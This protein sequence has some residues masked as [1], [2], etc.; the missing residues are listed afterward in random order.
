MFNKQNTIETNKKKKSRLLIVCLFLF[1]VIVI[2]ILI[3]FFGIPAYKY[4][5][6]MNELTVGN[7]DAAKE[8]FISLEDYRDS[9][10]LIDESDYLKAKDELEGGNYDIAKNI[11]NDLGEYKD[12]ESYIIEV[13]YRIAIQTAKIDLLEGLELLKKLGSYKD[14]EEL[15]VNQ[16]NQIFKAAKSSINR[17]LFSEAEEYLN[18]IPDIEG[19]DDCRNELTYQQALDYENKCQYLSSKREFEKIRGYKDVDEKLTSLNYQLDGDFIYGVATGYSAELMSVNF[20]QSSG[21]LYTH[22]LA[23]YE[24]ERTYF[25]RIENNIIYGAAKSDDVLIPNRRPSVEIGKITNI[26]K[27]ENGEIT[28]IQI[29]GLFTDEPVWFS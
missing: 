11:F 4:Q 9:K 12:S 2:G 16:K 3:R 14:S 10:D 5:K 26:V 1:F 23:G 29:S 6:A 19:V 15:V 17:R 28:K 20:F 25:Y 8:I 18:A 13:D 21:V 24:L 22:W 7:Y 27:G